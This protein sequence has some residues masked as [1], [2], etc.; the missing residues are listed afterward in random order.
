MLNKTY[1]LRPYFV[2]CWTTYIYCRVCNVCVF[3]EVGNCWMYAAPPPRKL[4]V[5][6][7]VSFLVPISRVHLRL[8]EWSASGS[9][10]E[11]ATGQADSLAHLLVLMPADLASRHRLGSGRVATPTRRITTTY[12]CQAAN[13]SRRPRY[14]NDNCKCAICQVST[15]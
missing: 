1:T 4:Q 5:C 9:E 7:C 8:S 6:L 14:L 10:Y 2:S 12:S 3:P 15:L 11:D 13:F